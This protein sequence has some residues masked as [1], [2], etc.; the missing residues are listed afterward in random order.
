MKKNKKVSLG[1]LIIMLSWCIVIIIMV[2]GDYIHRHPNI[3][4]GQVWVKEYYDDDPFKEVKR[5]TIDIIDVKGDYVL[6]VNRSCNDTISNTKH[7][8]ALCARRLKEND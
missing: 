8:T 7:W 6:Y 1:F 5:D 3:K 4:V 2:I